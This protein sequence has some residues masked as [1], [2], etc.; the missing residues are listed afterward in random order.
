MDLF[1]WRFFAK[2]LSGVQDK[3][4]LEEKWAGWAEVEAWRRCVGLLVLSSETE[5][6]NL[7]TQDLT[8]GLHIA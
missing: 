7:L 2:M 5:V 3:R 4:T 6:I 1:S 8:T